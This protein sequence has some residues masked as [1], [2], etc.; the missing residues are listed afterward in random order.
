MSIGVHPVGLVAAAAVASLAAPLAGPAHLVLDGHVVDGRE[1]HAGP[2]DVLD[3]GAL[4]E[5]G[6]DDWGAGGHEGRLA[7]VGEEGEDGVEGLEGLVGAAGID[8]KHFN[9]VGG[10][11]LLA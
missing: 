4:R 2:Q 5:E 11:F 3:A 8:L 6:V 7:E 9:L 1:A 10:V